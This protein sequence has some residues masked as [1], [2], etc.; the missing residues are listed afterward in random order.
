MW[1]AASFVDLLLDRP[2]HDVD[3]VV[4]GEGVAFARALAAELGG[5]VREHRKFLTSM[6]IYHDEDGLEQR[7]DVATARL[8]YYESP[9]ALPTVELSSIKMDLFR[10][11]FTIN[12]LAIR[13]DCTPY[14]QLVDF[15]GGQ[16]DIKEGVLRV[17]HTQSFVE[18]PTRSLRAVRFEQRYGFHIGPARKSSSRTCS[19]CTCWT[20]CPES[21]SSTNI[22]TYATKKTRRPVSSVWTAWACCGP[23]AF[24]VFDTEQAPDPAAGAFHAQLVPP[25]VF[26]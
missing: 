26:R 4:E 11:D 22:P 3:F 20:N 18:D 10:R 21:V 23:G 1:W 16:R 19:A 5:R 9:A 8:E 12:A 25:A 13:L 15:F 7:I 14:G 24:T 6:V 2:N 17:L